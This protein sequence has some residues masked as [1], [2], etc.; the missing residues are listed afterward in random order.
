MI[1]ALVLVCGFGFAATAVGL[2]LACRAV[3]R[4]AAHVVI[5]TD[6]IATT[7]R[8]VRTLADGVDSLRGAAKTMG[9]IGGLFVD[10]PPPAPPPDRDYGTPDLAGDA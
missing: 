7:G 5:G 6:V 2:F 3:N 10:S 8:N 4:L 1:A 9:A